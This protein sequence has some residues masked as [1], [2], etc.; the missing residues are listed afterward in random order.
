MTAAKPERIRRPQ[1]F[2]RRTLVSR[3]ELAR[4]RKRDNRLESSARSATDLSG[5]A[6]I[7]AECAFDDIALTHP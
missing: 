1:L 3:V 5:A 4:R 2:L 6:S 7:F